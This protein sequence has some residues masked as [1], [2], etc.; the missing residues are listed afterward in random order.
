MFLIVCATE[1]ELQ[2]LLVDALPPDREEWTTLVTGVGMV[3]TAL[4]LTRFLERQGEK[5]HAVLNIGVGGAYIHHGEE[6]AALLEICLAEQE[7]FGDFGICHPDRIEPL[8]ERLVKR[9]RYLLDAD[10][11]EKASTLL[12]ENGLAVRHG[13]F[14]TV[15][16]VSATASR[17]TMLARHYDALCENMEGA[18]VARVCEEYD[19]PLLE[20]RTI[21]NFVEERDLTRWKLSEA[22]EQAGKAGALLLKGL[23][24]E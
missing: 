23:T 15:C 5:I 1:F 9:S 14:V 24:N 20:M 22:C 8:A 13:N 16:G 19:L 6:G 17:G 18:A 7:I 2:P 12:A 3:E 10:L 4:S 11:L 21:S